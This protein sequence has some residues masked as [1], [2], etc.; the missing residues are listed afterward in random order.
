[1]DLERRDVQE[2]NDKKTVDFRAAVFHKLR[3]DVVR[4]YDAIMA[5]NK[6]KPVKGGVE[7]MVLSL[8]L[9]LSPLFLLLSLSSL[10]SP[11]CS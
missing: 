7:L 4:A 10:P 8:P 6:N 5:T 3:Q 2:R 1:M 9:S 11:S